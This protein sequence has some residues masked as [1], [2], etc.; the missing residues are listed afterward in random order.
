[1]KKFTLLT[2]LLML[3]A[4]VASAC[5]AGGAPECTD[6]IGCV[7]IGAD[8]PIRLAYMLTISGGT[9]FLGEDSRGGIEI[10]IDDRGE[11]LGHSIELVGEDSGCSAEGGQTAAQALATDTQ[12]VGIIGS[13]CSSEATAGLPIISDAGLLMISPSNT[14]PALTDPEQ[15]WKP[16]YYRTAHNDLFQGRVAAEF[17]YNELGA[18]SVA[19]IHDGS[20]Y[21]D[22]LQQV[23]ATTME[24]LGGTVTAREAIN[25][26]DTDMTA[27]LTQIA[28]GSPDVLY[29]PIFT[30]EGPFI[31]AQAASIPGLEETILM[32]SDGLL[33][34]NFA[35]DSGPNAVGSY[36]SG[37]YVQGATYDAFL[38]KWTTKYGG[39]P[40]SGFH[41]FAYDATNILLDAI[42]KV[43]QQG[44]D[45][46]LS[47]GRQA[48][49]DAV[50]ATSGFNGLTG[51]L[52]C[53][54][55]GD[56][57]TGQA[58]G[59]FEITQ[60]EVDGNFPPAAIWTP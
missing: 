42:V 59:I 54:E 27:I 50:S 31:V 45:G 3:T 28:A 46:S 29:F 40:P 25:V 57:A 20:P 23:F 16:G 4:L 21:A 60:A 53:S 2:I 11:L 9:A 48:L 44:E 36:L 58:L 56:C 47:I 18:R 39:S 7:E 8:E 35:P 22:Q 43:A 10:A 13:S 19:T 1:M 37:P 30:P 55:Y 5:A 51:T 38:A 15:T 24:E 32:G 49:R 34:E 33:A 12:I 26:G 14:A 6:P 52:T 41:A 17:A